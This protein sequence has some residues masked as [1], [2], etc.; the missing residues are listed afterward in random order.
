MFLHSLNPSIKAITVILSVILLTLVFDPITPL[1]FIVW[2]WILTIGVGKVPWKRYALFFSPF[3]IFSVGM[4]WTTIVFANEPNNPKNVISLLGFLVP[5]EDFTTALA[6]SLRMMS[7]TSLTLMFILTTNVVH[8]ILSL[9]QQ[10]K[11]PPKLAYGILAGYRFLPS[12]R[13]ELGLVRSAH[14]VRGVN[15]ASSIKE[16]IQQSKRFAVPLLA[17]AIRKAERT[18]TAMES[19]GFTDSRNRTFYRTFTVS[20]KDWL[21]MGL[22]LMMLILFASISWY[23]GYFKWYSSEF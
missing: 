14:R 7:F 19:K 6:L 10:C 16:S 12:M 4:F 17:S 22:M 11:M 23:L 18:A 9:M 20:K 13:E 21:F 3:L 15:R 5:E 2:I 1:L 8:L